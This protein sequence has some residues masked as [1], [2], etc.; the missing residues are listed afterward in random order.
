MTYKITES[1]ALTGVSIEREATVDEIIDFEAREQK[2]A[3]WEIEAQAKAQAKAELL[4]R[5]GITEDEAK[6]LFS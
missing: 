1:D 2:I 6:L 5:L 3:N 4:E